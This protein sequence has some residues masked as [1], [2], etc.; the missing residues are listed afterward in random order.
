MGLSEETAAI[1]DWRL[2]FRVRLNLN[3]LDEKN[4][5]QFVKDVLRR[6]DDYS[7][8]QLFVDFTSMFSLRLSNLALNVS[9]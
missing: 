8:H 7:V 4:V 9:F 2:V 1:Q 5:P 3:I 6:T